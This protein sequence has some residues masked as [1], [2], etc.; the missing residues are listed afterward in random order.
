MAQKGTL[1]VCGDA[2]EALGDSLYEAQLFVRGAVAG[3]GADCVAKEMRDE[4]RA[5]R[6]RSCWRP[7]RS[8]PTRRTSAATARPG[9]CTTSHV[10]N[11]GAY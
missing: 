1:V 4:H 3:L 2:G 5:Q 6:R 7:P 9:S 8:T 10:D 11:V